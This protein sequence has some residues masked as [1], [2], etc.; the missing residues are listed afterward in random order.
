MRLEV[1]HL[2][3]AVEFPDLAHAPLGDRLGLVVHGEYQ[4]EALRHVAAEVAVAL[5]DDLLRD[6]DR[7]LDRLDRS[8]QAAGDPERDLVRLG[9]DTA[10]PTSSQPILLICRCTTMRGHS[11]IPTGTSPSG[12]STVNVHGSGEQQEC[13]GNNYRGQAHPRTVPRAPRRA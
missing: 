3:N 8:E 13:G 10:A 1:V 9:V 7:R 6:L 11:G 5:L 12:T 2:I 4:V